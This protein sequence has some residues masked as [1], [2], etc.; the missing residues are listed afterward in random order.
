MIT[1]ENELGV[2]SRGNPALLPGEDQSCQL[3]AGFGL[4]PTEE[5]PATFMGLR[6]LMDSCGIWSVW[7]G[8]NCYYDQDYEYNCYVPGYLSSGGGVCL[9]DVGNESTG[10]QFSE[11]LKFVCE[12]FQDWIS[13]Q[14]G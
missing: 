5:V 1:I 10:C 8:L 9:A 13:G 6:R 7:S 2:R 3:V 11:A 12:T 4:P 14:G